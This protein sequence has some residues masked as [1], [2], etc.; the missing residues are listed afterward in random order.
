MKFFKEYIIASSLALVM[1]GCGGGGLTDTIDPGDGV[2]YLRV[3]NSS[4]STS[5]ICNVYSNPSSSGDWGSDR[6]SGTISSGYYKEFS[7]TNCNID[8]DLKVVFCDGY[9][10]QN[11]YYRPCGTTTTKTFRNW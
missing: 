7:T 10:D 3:G 8:Y 2:S 9:T 1:A 6:L 4:D 11:S 5:K